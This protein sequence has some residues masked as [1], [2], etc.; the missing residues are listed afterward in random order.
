MFELLERVERLKREEKVDR[1]EKLGRVGLLE[2]FEKPET[3]LDAPRK[4]QGIWVSP[5]D[6]YKF[7]QDGL[8]AAPRRPKRPPKEPKTPQDSPKRPRLGGSWAEKDAFQEASRRL[9]MPQGAPSSSSVNYQFTIRLSV[10]Y[11]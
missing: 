4:R 7:A 1:A 11:P 9:Q 8:Q 10:N 6:A 5:K 3:P 2:L